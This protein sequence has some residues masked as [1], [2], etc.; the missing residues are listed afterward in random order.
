MASGFLNSFVVGS[1]SK[2][3]P[4]RAYTPKTSA[5]PSSPKTTMVVA[6][7]PP[8]SMRAS[9][10]SRSTTQPYASRTGQTHARD[11]LALC[12]T[13]KGVIACNAF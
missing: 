9:P 10:I 7:S 12:K 1:T 2:P 6:L 11:N 3:K 13:F 8:H 4:S 5:S